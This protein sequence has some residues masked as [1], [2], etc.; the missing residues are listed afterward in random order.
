MGKF[1]V[2]ESGSDACGKATQSNLLYEHLK[3][4]N[5]VLKIE[6]PNYKSASSSLVKMYLRGDFGKKPEDVN[7]YNT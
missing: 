3:K 1:Y 5:K 4:D 2:I 7:P 6:F